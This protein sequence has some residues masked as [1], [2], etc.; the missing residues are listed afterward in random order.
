MLSEEMLQY[1][2]PPDIYI[3]DLIL[4][5]QINGWK[6]LFSFGFNKKYLIRT[7]RFE[8]R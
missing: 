2:K 7:I 5:V 8:T 6:N 4:I 3:I 1:S